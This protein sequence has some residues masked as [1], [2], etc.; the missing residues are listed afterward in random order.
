MALTIYT[1]IPDTCYTS[2]LQKIEIETN[3]T[4]VS[5]TIIHQATS[6]ISGN[7]QTEIFQSEY[8]TFNNSFFTIYD[9][10]AFL[11]AFTAG[12]KR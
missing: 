7:G 4:S 9:I 11:E 6:W 3:A 2:Q 1:D 8:A 12:I 10:G 5:L